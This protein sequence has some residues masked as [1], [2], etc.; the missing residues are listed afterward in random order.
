MLQRPAFSQEIFKRWSILA[1]LYNIILHV[2]VVHFDVNIF[3][4]V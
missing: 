3:T 2:A 1:F 4:I